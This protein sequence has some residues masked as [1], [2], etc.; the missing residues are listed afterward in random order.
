MIHTETAK[1]SR[2]GRHDISRKQ[3]LM[4]GLFVEEMAVN[5]LQH[6]QKKD[7]RDVSIDFRL[8]ISDS[9]V[10]FSMTDLGELF[11]PTSF[12]ELHQYDSAEE[13]IGIRTVMNAAREVRYF[14]T[15][16]SNNLIVYI[17]R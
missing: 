2:S 12:H 8:F 11:D 1:Q 7:I 13:H 3:A 15:F 4:A 16:S 6:A 14:S 5:V 9:T 17:D 10:C